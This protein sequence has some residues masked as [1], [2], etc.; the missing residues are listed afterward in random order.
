[1]KVTLR[2]LLFSF[3]L[4]AILSGEEVL[5][6]GS[7]GPTGCSAIPV[8]PPVQRASATA[9]APYAFTATGGSRVA[10]VNLSQ[11]AIERIKEGDKELP[12]PK[13]F[14]TAADRAKVIAKQ[15][16]LYGWAEDETGRPASRA[17]SHYSIAAGGLRNSRGKALRS[18]A[19]SVKPVAIVKVATVAKAKSQN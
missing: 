18:P 7:C 2:L 13:G 10:N 11:E 14:S 4:L 12:L 9:T 19:G 5:A 15:Q 8:T 6:G 17:Q 1:M 3:L 16:P